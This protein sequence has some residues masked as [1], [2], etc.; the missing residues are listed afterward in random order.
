MGL[1]T[2]LPLQLPPPPPPPRIDVDIDDDGGLLTDDDE[3]QLEGQKVR[4]RRYSNLALLASR[5]K[6]TITLINLSTIDNF[7]L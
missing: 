1:K 6:Y 5:Q 4:F 3:P 7:F 2:T